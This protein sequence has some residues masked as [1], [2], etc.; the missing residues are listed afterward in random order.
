MTEKR[1]EMLHRLLLGRY[2]VIQPLAM[3]GMGAVYLG[4][5]EGAAGFAKPVVIKR[6]LPHL[7]ASAEDRAQ[8][9]RE[10]RI[11]SQLRHPSIVNVVDFGQE[12]GAY[13]MVLE[14][15]NGYHLGQWLKYVVKTRK[16][17]PWQEGV[18]I[19]LEVLGALQYAHTSS[20]ERAGVIHRDIS[21]SNILL[22]VDARVRIVDF[23]VARVET[24]QTVQDDEHRS[25]FKGKLPYAAPELYSGATA[26]ASTDIYACAVI[27]YQ[28]LAG[29]NPFSGPDAAVIIRRVLAL[30]PAPIDS[31]RADVPKELAAVLA[32]ALLKDSQSRF[33]S[34][35][36]F[37][38]ALRGLLPRSEAD[39]HA[40][41]LTAIRADFSDG[42]P[43]LL[44]VP[45]LK[46]LDAAWRAHPIVPESLRVLP[47]NP[48][49]RL[50]A[51]SFTGDAAAAPSLSLGRATEAL[52]ADTR[53]LLGVA[54]TPAPR[55][56]GRPT[57]AAHRNL[58]LV[59][60]ALAVAA[61]AT[62]IAVSRGVAS[63]TEPKYLVV[64]SRDAPNDP[65][66]AD[67]QPVN[68]PPATPADAKSHASD[69]PARPT[70]E[71]TARLQTT[72]VRNESKSPDPSVALSRTFAKR[73]AAMQQC[74][75]SNA[76]D[77]SGT[78]EVSV[79]FRIDTDGTVQSASISPTAIGATPLGQC[80][81]QVARSTN[82]GPQAQPLTFSIPVTTRKR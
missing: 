4:R 61:V 76:V 11:L 18:Y 21:P 15:V 2:R 67:G 14:Y 55:T 43:K 25:S 3:G 52:A 82:F 22:D 7:T 81:V 13:L 8:F 19:I 20:G 10:A 31:L 9:V 41:M 69:N 50:A 46:Q 63:H 36:D 39:I 60:G 54:V 16:Q 17:M 66:V 1:D 30:E 38:T 37:S 80:L 42:L 70:S 75:H 27:L 68:A 6:I 62:A 23:G 29:A 26:T 59:A 57:T 33:L 74:F 71:N 48:T 78:P 45:S 53:G 58:L 35:K 56:S 64:E 51:D 24:E 12:N 73:Q 77:V 79:R 44:N 34:A 72:A 28:L 5:V 47:S 40:E 65:S 49:I 32:K